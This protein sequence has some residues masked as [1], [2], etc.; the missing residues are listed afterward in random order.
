[1][2]NSERSVDIHGFSESKATAVINALREPVCNRLMLEIMTEI[3]SG[4]ILAFGNSRVTDNGIYLPKREQFG[5][6]PAYCAWD[7]IRVEHQHGDLVISSESDQH[8]YVKISYLK[9]E[10]A[11]MLEM[12]VTYVLKK[13]MRKISDLLPPG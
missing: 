11:H 2:G 10:N 4:K 9:V 8:T 7:D 13:G 1:M 5:I 6:S 12:I 3:K